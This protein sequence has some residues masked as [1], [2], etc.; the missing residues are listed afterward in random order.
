LVARI[1]HSPKAW[2]AG[3]ASMPLAQ[4]WKEYA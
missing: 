4:Q 3:A 2:H 1:I